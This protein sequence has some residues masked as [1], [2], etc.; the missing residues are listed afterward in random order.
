MGTGERGAGA[1]LPYANLLRAGAV[2]ISMSG[3]A[4]GQQHRK[5][6]IIVST[7]FTVLTRRDC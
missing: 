6:K 4:A 1:D 2:M 5:T 3:P 7:H